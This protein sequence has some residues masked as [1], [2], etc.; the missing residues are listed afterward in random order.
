MLYRPIV[1]RA[2]TELELRALRQRVAVLCPKVDLD[3]ITSVEQA[4]QAL[5]QRWVPQLARYD[6]GASTDSYQPNFHLLKSS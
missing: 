1:Q 2:T 6:S 3:S 4:Q 5:E